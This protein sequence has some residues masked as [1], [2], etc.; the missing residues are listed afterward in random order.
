MLR[1]LL[2]RLGDLL[3]HRGRRILLTGGWSLASKACTAANLIVSIP[4]VLG[5]LGNLQFGAWATLVSLV[6]FAGFLDF[7]L[8]NGTMNL[9]A[10]AHGRGNDEE[11]A[12]VLREA[13][14]TL[15]WIAAS[16]GIAV[17]LLLP[18]IPWASLLGLP[19]GMQ[20]EARLSVAMVLFSVVVAIPLNLSNRVQLGL[21]RGDRAFQWQ[22]IGQLLSLAVVV[23]LANSGASLPALVCAAVATPLI[24]SAANTLAL[25]RSMAMTE[26]SARGR[27]PDLARRIRQEGVWFFILQLSAAIGF[28]ADLP[29]ISAIQGPTDAGTFAI[30]QR[31]FSIIPLCL[32]LVWTPLWPIYR[33][34]LASGDG[35]WVRRTLLRS[36]MAATSF[37]FVASAMLALSFGTLA[38]H[39]LGQPLL[40]GGWL[41]WGFALWCVVEATGTA[42]S[43]F[44]NAAS[45]LRY[46]VITAVVFALICLPSK[47]WVLASFGIEGVPW[48]TILSYT[49]AAIIPFA[50]FGRRILA[51]AFARNI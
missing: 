6:A 5:A 11:V 3:G 16:L 10:S 42:I 28:A 18:L 33:Q 34:A 40:Y 41:I 36:I 50:W 35:Q 27:R 48:A 13:R 1:N 30:V 31:A 12:H 17:G 7:G 32:G 24:G 26:S 21:G 22:A 43:T 14:R 9:V 47:A 45:V 38:A 15:A 37:A 2:D 4:F 51:A 46:Q 44:L 19:D 39:W 25:S 8:G 29:L 20:R 49:I 23:A